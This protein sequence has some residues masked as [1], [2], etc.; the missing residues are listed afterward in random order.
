VRRRPSRLGQVNL[1]VAIDG[2]RDYIGAYRVHGLLFAIISFSTLRLR[3]SDRC[4]D[5]D[6]IHRTNLFTIKT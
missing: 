5:L 2:D 6:C 4:R 1:D 3:L